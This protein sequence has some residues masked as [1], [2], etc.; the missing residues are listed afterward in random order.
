MAAMGMMLFATGAVASPATDPSTDLCVG[1]QCDVPASGSYVPDAQGS[2]PAVADLDE[3]R[4]QTES[5]FYQLPALVYRGAAQPRSVVYLAKAGQF[6][7]MPESVR[8]LSA[9]RSF[10]GGMTDTMSLVVI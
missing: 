10:S 1:L 5:G 8:N 9:A 2:V 6:G 7:R 3:L 4:A